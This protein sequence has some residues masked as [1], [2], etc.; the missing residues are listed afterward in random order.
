[1]VGTKIDLREDPA[2]IERL[3]EKKLAPISFAQG[4][5]MTREV[6]ASMYLECSA[7]TQR[8]LREVF[9]GAVKAVIAPMGRTIKKKKVT[10]CSLM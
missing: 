4:L 8:G 6:G 2:I 1:M 7:L 3:A 9:F 5:E 10:T